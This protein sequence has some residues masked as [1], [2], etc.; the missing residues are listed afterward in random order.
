MNRTTRRESVGRED[1]RESR[2]QETREAEGVHDEDLI[3][4]DETGPFP[5]I[6]DRPGYTRRWIRT[7]IGN[8]LDTRSLVRA[9]QRGWSPVAAES[10]PKA[11]QWMTVQ[12]HGMGGV[13]GTATA[14]LMERREEITRK[15][16]AIKRKRVTELTRG[17]KDNLFNE[18]R[19]NF[20]DE[21]LFTRPNVEDSHSTEVG[22][23]PMVE[24]D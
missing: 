9:A 10:V 6:P 18:H 3:L 15:V 24:D 2:E 19:Q 8:E 1:G 7:A 12:R 21:R 4:L 5:K 14:I 20:G 17:V 22:R 11:F 23:R 13:I 16:E